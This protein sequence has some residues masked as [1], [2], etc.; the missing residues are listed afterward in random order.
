MTEFC[1]GD[2]VVDRYGSSG[3]IVVIDNDSDL[4][5][6]YGVEYDES[7]S[8]RHNLDGRCESNHGW[9]LR[10]NALRLSAPL[11][12]DQDWDLLLLPETAVL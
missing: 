2:R 10:A 8:I 7:N 6:W 5:P 1:V 4:H 3:V 12:D 9:W 11:I